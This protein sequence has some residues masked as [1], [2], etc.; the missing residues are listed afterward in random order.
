MEEVLR[1][2]DEQG[3]DMLIRRGSKS[4]T[5]GANK[6]LDNTSQNLYR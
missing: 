2:H 4:P 5:R 1:A 6:P 3:M